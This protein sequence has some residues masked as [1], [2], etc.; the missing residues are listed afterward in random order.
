MNPVSIT[1][2]IVSCIMM[3][4]GVSTFIINNIRNSRADE[5]KLNT[6]NDEMKSSLLELN[7]MT[8][9]INTTTNDIKADVKSLTKNV[10]DIDTRVTLVEREQQAMWNRIDELKEKTHAK[11]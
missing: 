4:V 8:K 3:V 7:L 9:N 10:N 2:L 1:S 6:K 5:D 11:E